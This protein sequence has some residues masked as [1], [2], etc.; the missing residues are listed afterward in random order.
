MLQQAHNS[1]K[2]THSCIIY[3]KVYLYT[4]GYDPAIR[5]RWS[6]MI[7]NDHCGKLVKIQAE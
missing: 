1:L 2:F 3:L 6:V 7:V 5:G 4:Y